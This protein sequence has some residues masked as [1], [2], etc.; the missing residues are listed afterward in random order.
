MDTYTEQYAEKRLRI[1]IGGAVQGVGFR[2]FIYRL[3]TS[4]NLTG[5]VSNSS[6][7]CVGPPLC[8]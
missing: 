2:P 7:G 5:W 8:R 6:A 4:L 1:L 3:A